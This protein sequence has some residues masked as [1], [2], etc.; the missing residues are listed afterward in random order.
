MMIRRYGP[1]LLPLLL[2]AAPAFA[3]PAPLPGDGVAGKRLHDAHCTACHDS[4]VYT[5]KDHQV[6]TLDGLKQQLVACSH[7]A[8]R[9]LSPRESDDLVKYLNDAYYRF[10]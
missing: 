1:L 9:P 7:M 2:L 10:Q 3:A 5:R 4:G 6:R 8:N